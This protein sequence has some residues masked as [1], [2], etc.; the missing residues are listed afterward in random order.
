M[1][2]I[3]NEVTYFDDQELT[4]FSLAN[5]SDKSPDNL[6]G[7][8]ISGFIVGKTLGKVGGQADLYHCSKEGIEAVLKLF[9]PVFTNS[10]EKKK[11]FLDVDK[12][13]QSIQCPYV[14]KPFASGFYDNRYFRILPYFKNGTLLDQMSSSGLSVRERNE[15]AK[16]KIVPQV[17]AALHAIHEAGLFHC[18]LKPNNVFLSDSLDCVIG[19]F[20]IAL[21]NEG[22]RSS[23]QNE[24][25]LPSFFSAPEAA[26]SKDNSKPGD[27]FSFGR[28]LFAFCNGRDPM[29][30]MSADDSRRIGLMEKI[31]IPLE[32]DPD[33]RGLISALTDSEP[34]FRADYAAVMRWSSNPETLL[35]YAKGEDGDYVLP[36][37]IDRPNIKQPIQTYY[38]LARYLGSNWELGLTYFRSGLIKIL[39]DQNPLLVSKIKECTKKYLGNDEDLGLFLC[40]RLIGP[41]D[42]SLSYRSHLFVSFESFISLLRS[43]YDSPK[44]LEPFLSKPFVAEALSYFGLSQKFA[45]YAAIYDK[46]QKQSQAD[47]LL[48]FARQ[49]NDGI[50][51]DGVVYKDLKELVEKGFCNKNCK[52]IIHPIA[53]TDHLA[54]VNLLLSGYQ[55]ITKQK[56]M[57]IAMASNLSELYHQISLT[58][59][60]LPFRY[61]D[62][63]IKTQSDYVALV[64]DIYSSNGDYGG[65]VDFLSSPEAF[66]LLTIDATKTDKNLKTNLFHEK[67]VKDRISYLAF[68]TK[69]AAPYHGARS[70][71]DLGTLFDSINDQASFDKLAAEIVDDH[72]F[73][74]WLASQGIER[75]G[76]K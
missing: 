62:K 42:L 34:K 16:K 3:D 65:L 36:S 74:L 5:E 23:V 15:E 46:L 37:P 69:P 20:G 21:S 22:G 7:T 35:F 60:F 59:G 8:N 26:I 29:E 50:Y 68:K 1:T 64:K 9:R 55:G 17:N 6:E 40:L 14:I 61:G 54:F 56:I 45:P 33:L 2:I 48:N 75:K 31:I 13:L 66:D 30:R 19:D 63:Q 73:D 51:L 70:L 38:Q 32:I 43:N 52:L 24:N 44:N 67:T 57:E 72:D 25:V 11:L 71:F 10:E 49:S 41:K 76:K 18:D 58:Q 12:K 4:C 28:L 47:V 27:Y 53:T 39:G